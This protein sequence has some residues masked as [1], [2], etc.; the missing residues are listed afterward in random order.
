MPERLIA[1]ADVN[2]VGHRSSDVFF[3][4]SGRCVERLAEGQVR[5]NR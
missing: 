4:A 1:V 2:A 3:G 5:R